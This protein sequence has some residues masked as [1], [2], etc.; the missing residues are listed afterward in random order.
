MG[1]NHNMCGNEL[2]GGGLRSLCA[3]LVDVVSTV[4]IY[5]ECPYDTAVISY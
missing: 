3:F 4:V 5:G 2:L 1:G